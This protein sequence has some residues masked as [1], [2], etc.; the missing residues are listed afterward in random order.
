M[1]N[2][3]NFSDGFPITLTF[4]SEN[5]AENTTTGMTLANGGAGLVVPT[6]Y[7][8]HA[9]LVSASSN[10]AVQADTATVKVRANTTVLSNGPVAALTNTVQST[11]GTMRPGV[12]P[13]TAGKTVNLAIVTGAN[14][15]PNT[16]D[17]DAVL[18]GVLLPA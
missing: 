9:M 13:I 10:A 1:A 5:V 6:G 12:E 18:I 11:A 2:D 15:A 14:F 7:A 3:L 17:I 8:F 4:G 16:A